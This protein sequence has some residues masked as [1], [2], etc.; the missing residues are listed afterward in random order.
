MVEGHS[1]Q[2]VAKKTV[3][4]KLVGHKWQVS[5]P[6]GRISE[7]ALAKLNSRTFDAI[8]AVG[9]NLFC[10]FGGS[11]LDSCFADA[12]V[13]HVH[14]GMSGRWGIFDAAAAPS[15][16]STT[17]LRFEGA[18]GLVAH[19]SAMTVTVGDHSLYTEKRSKLGEDPL[20]E[21]ADPDALWA[22]V[23]KSKRTI[24]QCLMDQSMF[25]G[26]G[27]IYRAE[28]LFV[29]RVHPNVVANTLSRLEFDRIWCATL[30]LMTVGYET[31]R[32]TTVTADEAK[33]S[34]AGPGLR[35]WI[36]NRSRCGQCD[37][38]VRSWP[39]NSRTCYACES[40][41]PIGSSSASGSS[42][43]GVTAHNVKGKKAAVK[44]KEGVVFLSHCVSDP[45]T[46]RLATPMKLR[47]AEL[48]AALVELGVTKPKGK[49]ASLVA[50][51]IAAR[52]TVDSAVAAVQVV[53]TVKMLDVEE[54]TADLDL[55]SRSRI[56]EEEVH[57]YHDLSKLRRGGRK[58]GGGG[59]SR[60]GK[61][62]AA[63]KK[64]KRSRR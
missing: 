30:K 15:P 46:E 18:N 57:G 21:D 50:Q 27:N 47:V 12:T 26:V 2:R 64:K 35:R 11:P 38:V 33:A 14:F 7:A 19:V 5:S 56:K 37:G 55:T 10:F 49:K 17:R 54:H 22:S 23:R 58:R 43:S 40:C 24:G 9:K 28:I 45:L 42:T 60:G 6:N 36:Y 62:T 13:I 16:T 34:S 4:K 63:V 32:I 41:Q 52:E 1:V 29:A 25:A 20:R 39:V 44:K 8:E 61:K 3:G 48:K 31:G 53:K 59:G 51:L